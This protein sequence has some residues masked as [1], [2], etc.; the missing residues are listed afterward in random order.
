MPFKLFEFLEQIMT[1]AFL[2][3][4]TKLEKTRWKGKFLFRWKSEN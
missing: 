3:T 4:W 1:G 2:I